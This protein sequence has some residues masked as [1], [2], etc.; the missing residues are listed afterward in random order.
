M[1]VTQPAAT[2]A[3]DIS[4]AQHFSRSS[5][6]HATAANPV[7]PQSDAD[8]TLQ[9]TRLSVTQRVLLHHNHAGIRRS[10]GLGVKLGR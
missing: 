8:A 9:T 10:V 4:S 2:F 3:A 6:D 7:S 1:V 5:P